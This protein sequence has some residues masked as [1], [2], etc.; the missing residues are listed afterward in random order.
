MARVIGLLVSCTVV[1]GVFAL[2]AGVTSWAERRI[3]GRM[4]SRY[5]CNRVGPQGI[6]QFIAD[7]VKLILKEDLMPEWSDR[8]LFRVAA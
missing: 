1:F 8:F 6:W 5:G 7:A 3:A 2:I 4:Q